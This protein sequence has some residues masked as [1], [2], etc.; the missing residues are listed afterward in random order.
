MRRKNKNI[1]KKTSFLSFKLFVTILSLVSFISTYAA[2]IKGHIKD[3]KNNDLLLGATIYLKENNQIND[4]AGLEGSYTLKNVQPGTYTMVVQIFSYITQE[5]SVTVVNPTDEIIQ[6][7]SMQPDS[8]TLKEVQIVGGYDKESDMYAR[9]LEKNND[10][11]LNILSAKTIQLL[12]DITVGDILQRVSG[13][14]TEKSVTGGGKYAIIR[15]IDKRYNYT[16]I[17][18][19]KVPSPDYQN[20]YVPLDMFPAA[21]LER[22]EVIKTLRPD[23]EGDA[24]GGVMNLVLKNPPDYLSLTAEATSGYSQNLFN[25]NFNSFDANAINTKSPEAINGPTYIAS[26]SDFPTSPFMYNSV[27]ASPNSSAGFTFGDRFLNN[28]L[29]VILSAIYSNS[30]SQT[31]AF[32]I[33]PSAQPNW[34]PNYN[35]PNTPVFDDIETRVYSTQ[36]TRDAAHLKLD[37]DISPKHKISFYTFYV[38]MNQ[39]RSDFKIDTSIGTG[40]GTYPGEGGINKNYETKVTYENIYNATLQG[41]D[42]L[43]HNLLLD[44][45]GAYSRGF[46]NTPDWGTLS[47]SSS[48]GPDPLYYYSGWSGRWWQNTDQDYSG[49]VNLTYRTY[50][51]GQ[52]VKFKVGA[53]NRDKNR[54]DEYEDY[55]LNA[56]GNPDQYLYTP[57]NLTDTI[58][59]IKGS[60]AYG[61]QS[62]ANNYSV[63]EDIT[64]VFGMVNFNLGP[65]IE[66]M[67]G[68]RGE[69]TLLAY[70]T[71]F[72]DANA[73]FG[74]IHYIDYLP[75]GEIKFKI[76]DKQAIRASYFSSITRPNF[77][78]LMPYQVT[79]DYYTE[80]GNPYLLH[81]Q[82]QNYD[83]RYEYFP[84]ETEQF[85]A[86]VF[87]KNL[88]DPIEYTLSRYKTSSQ[89]LQPVNDTNKAFCYGFELLVTKYFWKY[90]GISANYTYTKSQTTVPD[91]YYYTNSAGALTTLTNTT[92]NETRPLQGQADNVG[93][94]SF[95]YKNPKMGLDLNVSGIYTG[96]LISAASPD[97][98]LDMWQMPQVR[99][100]FSFQQRVSKKL[101]LS[102]FGKVNN[103]LNT[104][105]EIR[106]FAPSAYNNVGQTAYLPNQSG[107]GLITDILQEKETYG[108]F[109]TLGVRYKF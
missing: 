22:L 77:E 92:V 2:T 103:I 66:V 58:W 26:P 57:T 65:K 59:Q 89:Y 5:R 52:E 17:N 84:S 13:V 9:N 23:M 47:T 7:F 100:D 44:W 51:F 81:T 24:I 67:G 4:V 68:L 49:Y 83:L 56:K 37:Y 109:Y 42:S 1:M 105:L 45:T 95:I 34:G 36:E 28:K 90:Y 27:K 18:G 12:P 55:S 40:S 32:F 8:L 70:E 80:A 61:S 87:Y 30:Y 53:M 79:G 33:T 99:L 15:G 71:P 93:N 35:N 62:N 94:L 63:Q 98:G 43:A 104:P 11:I 21:I 46:S 69:N 54:V 86:G 60:E 20:S 48:A 19:V 39:Y 31:N 75:S 101:K 76:T 85:L 108:Q 96:K 102:I 72:D 29:G 25:N 50:I 41:Q 88:I 106:I 78:E 3:S 14:I 107:S 6:D 16:T 74:T 91:A 82:A 97:Y 10:Y 64:A 38:G 73:Q